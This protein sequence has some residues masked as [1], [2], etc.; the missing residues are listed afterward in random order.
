MK[1]TLLCSLC[2]TLLLPGCAAD[3]TP[4]YDPEHF[5]CT[6]SIDSVSTGERGIFLAEYVREAGETVLTI[7]APE[8]LTGLS[9][10]FSESGCVMDA[11]GTAV[12][13][14]EDAAASLTGL[15]C[16]L[17]ASPETA[18]DRK[19][20]A[21]GTLLFFPTGQLTL[22]STG[23]PLLAET[24]DGRRAEVTVTPKTE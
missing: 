13:L 9:F 4:A 21:D 6:L 14:S 24:A 8:R 17:E 7:T 3:S 16:L 11:A 15:V 1:H 20:T 22:D 23:L 10:T 5:A 12:P 2:L 19:K 18:S